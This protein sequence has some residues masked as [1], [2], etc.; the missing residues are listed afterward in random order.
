MDFYLDDIEEYSKEDII[1]WQAKLDA[2]DEFWIHELRELMNYGGHQIWIYLHNGH[3]VKG[4]LTGVNMDYIELN[5]SIRYFLDNIRDV[6]VHGKNDNKKK[7]NEKKKTEI[8]KG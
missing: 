8:I 6:V 1:D 3:R 5:N 2:I 7:I 4:I